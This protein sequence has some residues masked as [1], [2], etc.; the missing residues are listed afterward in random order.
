MNIGV[1]SQALADAF[2]M[3]KF[4]NICIEGPAVKIKEGS[5]VEGSESQ[6]LK[7]VLH[8]LAIK[9]CSKTLAIKNVHLVQEN[10]DQ[11]RNV[12]ERNPLIHD[13]VLA[14]CRLTDHGN[15]TRPRKIVTFDLQTAETQ[16]IGARPQQFDFGVRP[17]NLQDSRRLQ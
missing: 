1:R 6:A 10:I 11:L 2:A 9:R 16:G 13:I 12:L 17:G 14:D 4:P 7:L 5:G 15:I 8:N 3:M